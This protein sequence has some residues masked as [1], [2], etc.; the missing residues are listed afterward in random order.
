MDLEELLKGIE[1]D[2]EMNPIRKNIK[3]ETTRKEKA[4]QINKNKNSTQG[5]T[6]NLNAKMDED[7]PPLHQN[8]RQKMNNNNDSIDRME[9][10]TVFNRKGIV[11]DTL[12]DTIANARHNHE[13]KKTFSMEIV[14]KYVNVKW[15]KRMDQYVQEW[16]E[17][18]PKTNIPIYLT[19]EFPL[20]LDSYRNVEEVFQTDDNNVKIAL[21]SQYQLYL[22]LKKNQLLVSFDKN[23]YLKRI[24]KQFENWIAFL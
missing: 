7:D 20:I 17:H 8:K 21:F 12:D 3:E 24:K 22:W 4:K 2:D 16:V 10:T 14:K 11:E 19:D 23:I 18:Q 15:M 13:E 1:S 5:K 9:H 6:V